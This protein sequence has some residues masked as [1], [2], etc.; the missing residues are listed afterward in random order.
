M[1][2]FKVSPISKRPKPTKANYRKKERNPKRSY[3][4]FEQRILLRESFGVNNIFFSGS[5]PLDSNMRI[6]K[7]SPISKRPKPPKANYTPMA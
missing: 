1:R 3:P 2:I 6:F 5:E 7:V 4:G